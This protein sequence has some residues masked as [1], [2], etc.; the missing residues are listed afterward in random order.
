MYV[1]DVSNALSVIKCLMFVHDTSIFLSEYSYKT[2]Y[3]KKL[4]TGRLLEKYKKLITG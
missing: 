2:L 4:T 3:N 1:N